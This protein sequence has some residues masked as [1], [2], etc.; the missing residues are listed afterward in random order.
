MRGVCLCV[1]G[2]DVTSTTTNKNGGERGRIISEKFVYKEI[3]RKT[4]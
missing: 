3:Q 1:G 2:G 4:L